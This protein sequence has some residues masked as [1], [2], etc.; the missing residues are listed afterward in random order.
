VGGVDDDAIQEMKLREAATDTGMGHV[1]R[2]V[3]EAALT[4]P[5]G[6]G[7]GSAVRAGARALPAALG[8]ARGA[9]AV[10]PGVQ[11][12]A[13]GLQGPAS[14]AGGRGLSALA[15]V[16]GGEFAEGAIPSALMSEPG[17]AVKEG[18]QGGVLNVFLPRA[19]GAAGRLVTGPARPAAGTA[20]ERLLARGADLTPGQA[21]PTSLWG[22]LEE[23]AQS[24]GPWAKNAREAGEES[25]RNVGRRTALMPG[26]TMPEGT[27]TAKS[28]AIYDQLGDAY[29]KVL[30]GKTLYPSA[31]T[32]PKGKW[33]TL[34]ESFK[35]V[36]ASPDYSLSGTM[37]SPDQRAK[38]GGFLT[39][40]LGIL[41]PDAGVPPAGALA[42]VSA[43]KLQKVRENIRTAYRSTMD[44]AEKA[45]LS[46]A[47]E[48]VSGAI[49]T[50]LP[51]ERAALGEIDKHYRRW[52]TI[53]SAEAQKNVATKGGKWTA[54]ELER[55]ALRGLTPNRVATGADPSGLRS[56][57]EDM[58]Q[59]TQ[60]R[61]PP[62][63]QR[64][65]LMAGLGTAGAATGAYLGGLPGEV[66]GGAV[67]LGLPVLAGLAAVSPT[68]RRYLTGQYGVQKF[69]SS[70]PIVRALR[71]GVAVP[72][73]SYTVEQLNE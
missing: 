42:E 10:A 20:A 4:A 48:V 73:S 38:V 8:L 60:V 39:D 47:D 43:A 28:K 63:G 32:G 69:L 31:P 22:Q 41:W 27:A 17:N 35:R 37:V 34:D 30:A 45:L 9:P 29:D 68:A 15:G 72:A 58:Y 25:I 19:L 57:A 16:L 64:I 33:E 71:A 5:I 1:G 70:E 13:S 54:M 50:Q 24:I 66:G 61:S 62:T 40:Q 7:A 59:V 52:A 2:F 46:K 23:F 53:A 65:A 21:N 67:G 12:L 44:P 6:M 49:G 55:G 36:V 18:V 14:S 11:V 26:M 51:A 56:L 3:G